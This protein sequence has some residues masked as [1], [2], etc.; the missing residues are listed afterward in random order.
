M[1]PRR[2]EESVDDAR[3]RHSEPAYGSGAENGAAGRSATTIAAL[4]HSVLP[5]LLAQEILS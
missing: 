1:R 5:D 2:G 3:I 4:N